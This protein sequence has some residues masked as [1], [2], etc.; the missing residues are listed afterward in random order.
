MG[1]PWVSLLILAPELSGT[2]LL[3]KDFQLHLLK[4]L[5]CL[6]KYFLLRSGYETT[7][8]ICSVERTLIVEFPY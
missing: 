2:V 5:L 6:G 3:K 8:R 4:A 7:M 1:G